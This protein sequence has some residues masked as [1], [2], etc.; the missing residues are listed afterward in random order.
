MGLRGHGTRGGTPQVVASGVR[1]WGVL[2]LVC[3]WVRVTRGAETGRRGDA[4]RLATF[5]LLTGVCVPLHVPVLVGVEPAVPGQP[6]PMA[7]PL[8]WRAGI[9]V[10]CLEYISNAR[11]GISSPAYDSPITRSS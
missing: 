4:A 2:R 6:F 8:S 3:D 5:E 7:I 10:G 11:N 1:W 9:P